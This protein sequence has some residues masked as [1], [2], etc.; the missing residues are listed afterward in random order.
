M[1]YFTYFY[2][3]LSITQHDWHTCLLSQALFTYYIQHILSYLFSM[4]GPTRTIDLTSQTDHTDLGPVQTSMNI[5]LEGVVH[6]NTWLYY[7]RLSNHLLV[8]L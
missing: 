1:K 8:S 4:C 2:T 3:S 6:V 7:I 5:L